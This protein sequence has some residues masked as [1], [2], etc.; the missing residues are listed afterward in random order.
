MSD[1]SFL[2]FSL[3]LLLQK[4]QIS[5][6]RK[7]FN[8]WKN[9]VRRIKLYRKCIAEFPTWISTLTLKEQIAHLERPQ[10]IGKTVA[11]FGKYIWIS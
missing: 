9:S 10:V 7:Y 8:I 4:Q 11:K 3:E 6:L 1:P 5:D 2:C